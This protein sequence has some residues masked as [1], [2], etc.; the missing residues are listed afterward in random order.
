M[1]KKRGDGYICRGEKR[2]IEVVEYKGH[3]ARNASTV[4]EQTVKKNNKI[5]PTLSPI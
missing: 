4:C 1:G 2:G 5:L 3:P